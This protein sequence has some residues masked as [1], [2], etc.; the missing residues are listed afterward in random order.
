MANKLIKKII[1]AV[2]P[3]K[4]KVYLG[5]EELFKFKKSLEY[6]SLSYSQEGEDL[7]LK[8]FLENK[9]NGFYVDVGAHHPKRFSNTFIF[10]KKGWRGI[11]IDPLPGVMEKFINERP[12]DIN[13]ELGISEKDQQ[14]TY[15]MFNE[16][17]LNT[18]SK[19]EADLKNGLRNY[20]LIEEK[21]IQTYPL[22]DILSSSLPSNTDID[23]MTID[24]EGLDFEV[25]QSND[26]NR[27]RPHLLLVEDLVKQSLTD[28]QNNSPIFKFLD[29]KEY[30]LIGKTYNT[31]IFE[32]NKF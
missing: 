26:W 23:F 29:E 20:K 1:K 5:K 11:N 12:G 8:R 32:D 21:K 17:A 2:I 7:I 10:Y 19:K 24:V 4:V 30:S 13:L 25:L 18:F 28:F 9:E 31:L 15:Y 27:F 14:M 3:E 22:K 16:P 6:S